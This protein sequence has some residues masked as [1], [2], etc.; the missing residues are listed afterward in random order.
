[1]TDL[2]RKLEDETSWEY[3][4][5]LIEA[6]VD[7]N[8]DMEWQD[9]VEILE[10]DCHRDSLRKA[11]NVTEYS[12]IS[13]AKYYKQKIEDIMANQGNGEKFEGLIDELKQQKIELQKER[14]KLAD[15]RRQYHSLIRTEARW[16][17]LSERIQH[18]I[19]NLP[20]LPRSSQL[21]EE[22]EHGAIASVLLSDWHI[23]SYINTYHNQ[24]NTE[25]A[26][27]RVSKLEQ[28][29]IK[30]CRLHN[31]S[32]LYVNVMGDLIS[33]NIHISTRLNNQ[34]NVVRQTMLCSELL[35][36]F[37]HNLSQYIKE[38][39]VNFTIG[40]HGRVSANVKESL[41]EENFEYLI[42]EFLK[43]RLQDTNV[44]FNEVKIDKEIVTYEVFNKT[45]ACVHG[46]REKKVFDSVKELS[47]FLGKKI[48]LVCCGHFHNFATRN[49]VIING[50]LSGADE[51]ANNLRFNNAPSQTLVIHFEN[52]SQALYEIILK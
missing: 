40:N 39:V 37:I 24:F 32:K 7:G 26:Q 30:Y 46:H 6:K 48:D 22:G 51:Y 27:E 19:E 41:D 25:I 43:L 34:E 21:A 4:L 10:L 1:M 9:L 31:V 36:T 8:I 35:A 33:G 28:D 38:V 23:G 16:E 2:L 17:V 47:Y 18:A 45:V 20:V 42:L 13:V 14:V 50:A 15:E 11:T 49:N 12:G 44:Q 29:V 5:R 52:E 3:G